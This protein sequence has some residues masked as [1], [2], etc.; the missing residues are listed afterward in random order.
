MTVDDCMI[1]AFDRLYAFF[2]TH[3]KAA[4]FLG[5][6]SGH[7][8]KIRTGRYKITEVMRKYILS[9]AKILKRATGKKKNEHRCDFV[10]S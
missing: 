4:K 1:N 2:G 9:Q 7:Y 10:D 3:K 6:S 8:Q 5:I